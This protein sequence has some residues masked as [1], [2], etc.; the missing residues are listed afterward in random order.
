[1]LGFAIMAGAAVTA[2][3]ARSDVADTRAFIRVVTDFRPGLFLVVIGLVVGLIA[4]TTAGWFGTT[5][6]NDT[7]SKASSDFN[8]TA[9]SSLGSA[10]LGWLGWTL[11][12]VSAIVAAAAAW[13][14]N[15]VLAW[16]GLAISIVSVLLTFLTLKSITSV[17]A[18][19]APQYGAHWKNLGTGGFVACIAF[20]LF[21]S[22]MV[23]VL[24]TTSSGL[25]SRRATGAKDWA[26]DLPVTSMV[27]GMKKSSQARSLL[28]VAGAV[29]L[30]YPPTLPVRGRT[31]S[32]ARSACSSYWP[33]A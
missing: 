23:S 7:L 20:S 13:W 25:R 26:K 19:V 17:G 32:S 15:P 10:Y 29:A 33:S 21:A 8:G 12:G 6:I 14:R 16:A 9:I 22:G 11:L 27:R 31:C 24:S 1:M 2:V 5:G 3:Q 30:F 4:F 18:A 28:V